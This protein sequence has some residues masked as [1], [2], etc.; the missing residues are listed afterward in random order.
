MKAQS[1]ILLGSLAVSVAISIIL[2]LVIAAQ[3]E[4][5]ETAV[6]SNIIS[7]SS[8]Q[9][10]V[11]TD[12]D[13][14]EDEDLTYEEESAPESQISTSSKSASKKP[15][16]KVVVLNT[17]E[18]WN[19]KSD[20]TKNSSNFNW[21]SISPNDIEAG[22]LIEE[23]KETEAT[24]PISQ[25]VFMQSL[26]KTLPF[27]VECN[28]SNNEITV[29]L[30]AGTQIST[31]VPQ[32]TTN[33]DKILFGNTEIKSGE[34]AFNFTVPIELTAVSGNKTT[35]YTVYVM[36]YFDTGLPS[37][38]INTA[39]FGDVDSKTEYK[40]CSVFAGGGDKANGKYSFSTN[41]YIMADAQIKGRGWTSW[42]HY[43]KKSYT[44]KFDKKQ[45]MLGLPAHTE[46]VL[47]AN[48]ADRT[49]MRNAVAMELAYSLGAESVMDVRFV[50][51]WVNGSYVGNYQL[52]E[53]IEVSPNR[54][55]IAKF[56]EKLPPDQVGY[57][58]ETNG[59]NKAE[60]EFGKW[61]NGQDADR[62]S[63][64]QKLN[65][66]ITLDPIS[67][68]MFFNSN[69]YG[70]IIF[71]VNKP[72]DTKL[73]ALKKEQQL[74]Y[75]E[76][77][78]DYM[79]KMEAAIKSRNYSEA[80]K[81]LDMESMAKWYIVEELAMNTDSNLHC[82]CYMYKDAGG[83]MKMGPV[84]D[85]DLG[86][87]NGK[88]ANEKQINK[89][90]LDGSRWF[91]DLLAM[92]QFKATVK[93]VWNKSYSKVRHLNKFINSTSE[94]LQV[95]QSV[96]YEIWGITQEAEHAYA[97]TTQN[98]DNYSDQVEYLNKFVKSRIEYMNGK[99]KSW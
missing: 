64:W 81:Y 69:Y 63:K 2:T 82:S 35:K 30:P 71:N 91:A 72:S 49:L 70:G 62:P 47:S 9:E 83:K 90:Y 79:D 87:G 75:L 23:F 53:K 45:E 12:D 28:I 38:V 11:Y 68:D 46:W 32:F 21:P 52:I 56:D 3:P 25:F 15:S 60:G 5:V 55:N 86:F 19:S 77:I 33:C 80:S 99:I 8:Q 93:S 51:L 41:K 7:S 17:P 85:F 94:M 24:E 92:P 57:I 50:D 13:F 29:V 34:V 39:D 31:L 14:K 40:K 16:G 61:T 98:I 1:K 95:A 59:H 96:N 27:S 76:Y 10:Y 84:W 43:P 78:Y 66:N 97:L 6:S 74:K 37:M 89:T 18:G 36:T 42:Y 58:I 26:N 4:V 48:F 20:R 54:V 65:E 22:G 73:L 88:Y 44:L 67:G